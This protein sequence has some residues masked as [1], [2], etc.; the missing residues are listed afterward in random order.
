MTEAF[1]TFMAAPARATRACLNRL[2]VHWSKS[3][4]LPF[5]EDDDNKF[6]SGGTL[7]VP[8]KVI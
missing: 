8:V 2:A 5:V 1:E 7:P 4:R 3:I 6:V